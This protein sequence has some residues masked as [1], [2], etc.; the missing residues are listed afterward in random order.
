MLAPP[1][2]RENQQNRQTDL[3][4]RNDHPGTQSYRVGTGDQPSPFAQDRAYSWVV[5]LSTHELV[6][7]HGGLYRLFTE[8][9]RLSQEQEEAAIQPCSMHPAVPCASGLCPLPLKEGAVWTS[10]GPR[11]ACLKMSHT[12]MGI[13]LS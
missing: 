11:A 5:G 2:Y 4:V 3:R 12:G 7:P 9:K 1:K 6:T 10:R 8:Q 13:I